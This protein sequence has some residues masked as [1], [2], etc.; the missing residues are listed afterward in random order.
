MKKFRMV[1]V[2]KITREIRYR[3]DVLERLFWK[4]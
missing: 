3:L 4:N 1:R 2:Y